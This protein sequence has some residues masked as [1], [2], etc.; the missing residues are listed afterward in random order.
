MDHHQANITKNLK[1]LVHKVLKY[2]FY[3]MS[4]TFI[5]NLYKYQLLD[6]LLAVSCAEILYMITM[7]VLPFF[8]LISNNEDLKLLKLVIV[9]N[10]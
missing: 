10:I 6:V 4:F 2:Q 1:T 9:S 8:S 7:N 3:W 5:N